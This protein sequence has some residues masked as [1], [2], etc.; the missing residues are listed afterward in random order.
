MSPSL[1]DLE[2]FRYKQAL[3]RNFGRRWASYDRHATVQPWMGQE[4]LREC[5]EAVLRAGRLLEVG[6]GTGIFTAAL[7]ELNPQATLVAVDLDPGL[8]L[9][10]RARVGN[11]PGVLW[12][13]A[14]GEAWG[15]G[16]YDLII[17]NSVFQWFSRPAETLA[18]YFQLLNPGG[19]LAFAALGPA[20]FREL[21]GALGIASKELGYSSPYPIAAA[22]FTSRETWEKYLREAGFQEVRL[23]GCLRQ[24][25][26]PSV[27]DFLRVLKLTGATNPE[28]RPFPPR[29]FRR[30][31]TAYREAY[32]IN[33]F[34]PVTY[35]AIWA[36][37]QK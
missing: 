2:C 31:L 3:R 13:A 33:G 22:G 15:G 30:L 12:V 8:L 11:G 24:E 5:R 1:P 29:L 32:G 6:C 36:V 4:L 10:A 19:T 16:P 21:A 37:A 26:F 35:E 7:R 25:I 9:R 20:T 18:A 17:S 14:D 27:A 28:P 34:I 23:R